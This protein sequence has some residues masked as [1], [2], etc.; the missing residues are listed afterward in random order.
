MGCTPL[1]NT[2]PKE[3]FAACSVWVFPTIVAPAALEATPILA[4]LVT[5]PSGPEGIAWDP[6]WPEAF[7]TT[8]CGEA[9]APPKIP[10]ILGVVAFKLRVGAFTVTIGALME[11]ELVALITAFAGSGDRTVFP[12]TLN[13][14]LELMVKETSSAL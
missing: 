2:P 11:M 6:I 8:I 10:V 9:G 14:P 12:L 13:E 4:I 7:T 3:A 5:P 1:V